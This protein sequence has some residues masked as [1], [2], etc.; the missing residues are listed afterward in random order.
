[1]NRECKNCE[2]MKPMNDFPTYKKKNTGER[3][4]RYTCKE[5][6]RNQQRKYLSDYYKQTYVKKP[7][8]KKYKKN[9]KTVCCPECQHNFTL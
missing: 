2:L 3:C 6:V 1:M 9:P 4:H 5:C 8:P 7:R